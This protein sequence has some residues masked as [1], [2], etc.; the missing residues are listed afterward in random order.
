M[1]L[2]ITL[3]IKF[4]IGFF[5]KLFI[6]LT[7]KLFINSI[8]KFLSDFLLDFLSNFLFNFLLNVSSLFQNNLLAK[9]FLTELVSFALYILTTI[10]IFEFYNNIFKN[11]QKIG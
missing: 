9:T 6:I 11:S 1:K 10:F 4:F 5:I 3:M 7:I 8:S 2:V